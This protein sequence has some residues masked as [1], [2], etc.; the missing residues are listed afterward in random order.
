[1]K[2]DM[3]IIFLL[4]SCFTVYIETILFQSNEY[5]SGLTIDDITS[6]LA[7]TDIRSEVYRLAKI[8]EVYR[9]YNFNLPVAKKNLTIESYK[10]KVGKFFICLQFKIL[11]SLWE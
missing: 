10:E 5:E 4:Y 9:K 1:M 6:D 7:T 2:P 8:P 3:E 11:S